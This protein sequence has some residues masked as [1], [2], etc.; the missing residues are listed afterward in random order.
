MRTFLLSIFAIFVLSACQTIDTAPPTEV[1]GACA[2]GHVPLDE[3]IAANLP[4]AGSK[5]I[6]GQ[7]TAE[8]TVQFIER[9]NAMFHSEEPIVADGVSIITAEGYPNSFVI[10]TVGECAAKAMF[11]KNELVGYWLNGVAGE[12]A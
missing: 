4:P 12:N 3:F 2:E 11:F 5:Y 6:I 10:F 9:F 8:R 1:A 7:L